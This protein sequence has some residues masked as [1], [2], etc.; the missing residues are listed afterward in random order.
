LLAPVVACDQLYSFDL[1]EWRSTLE[2]RLRTALGARKLNAETFVTTARDIFDRISTALE[3][4]GATDEH[5]ALNYSLMQHPGLFLAAAE[6]AGQ[7]VLDRV[8]TRLL[9]GAGTRRLVNVI[10][11]FLDLTTGVPERLFCRVDVTEEWP[12]LA[13]DVDGRRS[14][15]GLLPYVEGNI[16]GMPY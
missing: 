4:L 12:F 13:D 8:E 10:L 11:T 14:P 9:Q 6:R 5:R 1:D 7:Q 3:N 16:L 2:K 15:L